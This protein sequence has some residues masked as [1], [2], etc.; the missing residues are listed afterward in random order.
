MRAARIGKASVLGIASRLLTKA[1]EPSAS[2]PDAEDNFVVECRGKFA[3]AS[4]NYPPMICN[5]FQRAVTYPR[6]FAAPAFGSHV[7]G[8]ALRG[9]VAV[10]EEHCE[11]D[12]LPDMPLWCALVTRT[13]KC[14]R[15]LRLGSSRA[16]RCRP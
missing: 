15:E 9:E 3:K 11:H 8:A 6:V 16:H 10:D 4:A 13:V 2:D 7:P 1:F 14:P 12:S 5:T